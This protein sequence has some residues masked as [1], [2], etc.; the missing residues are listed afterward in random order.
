MDYYDPR[1]CSL[2]NY[3]LNQVSAFR[4]REETTQAEKFVAD[5][6]S[7]ESEVEEVKVLDFATVEN[8]EPDDL[9]DDTVGSGITFSSFEIHTMLGQGSFGKVF[10]VNIKGV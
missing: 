1:D 8:E 6:D 7:N 4:D 3:I 5:P 2:R 9:L 10:K